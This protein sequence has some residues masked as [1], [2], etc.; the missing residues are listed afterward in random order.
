MRPILSLN[1]NTLFVHILSK[2]RIILVQ[3]VPTVVIPH[4]FRGWKILLKIQNL[5]TKVYKFFPPT[6]FLDI[7][8]L[9][10]KILFRFLDAKGIPL[11]RS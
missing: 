2:R 10:P 7:Y 6:D 9:P 5:A 4:I 11:I 3:I 1:S 8:A